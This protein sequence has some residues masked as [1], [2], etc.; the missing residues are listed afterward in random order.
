MKAA[1]RREGRDSLAS[2]EK[3]MTGRIPKRHD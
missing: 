1:F 2:L 3:F